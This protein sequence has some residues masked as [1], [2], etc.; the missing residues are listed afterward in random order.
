MPHFTRSLA[1]VI[2]IDRYQNGIPAL[3]T[4]SNDARS[5]GALLRDKH[6]YDLCLIVDEDATLARLTA[7]LKVEL[8]AQVGPEDRV[9]FYFA[10]H[11]VALNGDD[12]PQGFILPQDARRDSADSF[13][14]MPDLHDALCA[15]N[16]RHLLAICLRFAGAFRWSSTRDIVPLPSVLH[17]ERYD[18]FIRDPA[19]QVISSAAHDEKA[20]DVLLGKALGSR[21]GAG[22]ILRS[23]RCS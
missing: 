15:L 18:R 12:G 11:G 2:G 21:G 23:P 17:Q 20:L 16:C 9:F 13:I 10:G 14:P 7:I 5:V 22:A 3:Q 8:P 4:A 19:W 6:G 1:V